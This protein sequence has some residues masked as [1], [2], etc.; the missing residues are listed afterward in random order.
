M[1]LPRGSLPNVSHKVRHLTPRDAAP[2]RADLIRAAQHPWIE[3]RVAIPWV[4]L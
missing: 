2:C 3:R 4:A 1:P